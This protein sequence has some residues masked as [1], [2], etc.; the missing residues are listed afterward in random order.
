MRD[1]GLGYR[2]FVSISRGYLCGHRKAFR[3]RERNNFANL[4][5]GQQIPDCRRDV[6]RTR[7]AAGGHVNGVPSWIGRRPAGS[8]DRYLYNGSRFAGRD[9]GFWVARFDPMSASEGADRLIG[10]RGSY[11]RAKWNY[12]KITI[13]NNM[14]RGK[15][16][17]DCVLFVQHP[18]EKGRSQGEQSGSFVACAEVLGNCDRATEGGIPRSS[19]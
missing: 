15:F 4:P 5:V 7:L 10:V 12:S 8:R 17:H 9:S 18:S 6:V 2:A 3:S 14:L 16:D 1:R 19:R 11:S 13:N